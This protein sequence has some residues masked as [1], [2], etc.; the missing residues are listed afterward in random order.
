MP[1][2]NQL[3][4]IDQVSGGNQI[5]TYYSGSGDA[6][7]MS[8]SLLQ[9][10]MQENLSFP[11]VASNASGVNYNPAGAGAVTRTVE[12]KL[13]ESVSVKDFGAVGDGVTDDTAAIQAAID[14]IA[15][16]VIQIPKGVYLVTA[17]ILVKNGIII[18]GEGDASEIR[19]NSD[20]EVFYSSRATLN[21]AVFQVEF[22]S[23][24]I[25]K[26]VTG[27]TTKYDIHLYNPHI[28]NIEQVHIKSGHDD[29]S[30]SSTNVGGIWLDKPSGSTST[31]FMNRIDNCWIQNNSIYLR[32]ITDSTIN[33]GYVWGHTRQFAIR[34]EGGGANAVEFIVGLICSKFNG[35]IW[36]DGA[37]VNQIRIHGNE[38]DGNP[39]LDTGTGVYCPQQ[40]IAVSITGN[41]FWGCDKH[42]IDTTDPVGWTIAGNAFW[43]N[44]AADNF[45]DDVRI[46]GVT[47]QP[48][49]NTV[50][51]N[52]HTI[53]DSRTNKGY[54]IREVNGGAVPTGNVYSSNGILGPT[55][56]V[57]PAILVLSSSTQVGN[58][59]VGSQE[60]IK[61]LGSGVNVGYE[62]HINVGTNAVI[63]ASGTLDLT[64]NTGSYFG[65]P[66]GFSGTLSVSTTRLNSA[67]QSRRTVYAAVGYG[68]TA[69]FTSLASQDGSGGGCSFTLSMAANGVIRFTDTSG[70]QVD[71]RMNFVGTKGLA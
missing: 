64:V 2:I 44:N 38:F 21:T 22:R 33:G 55:G 8:V 12:A 23:L 46:T 37:G 66:G 60:S 54:A 56:Y 71:V 47:F 11:G 16:G 48:N 32:N 62:N 7:K 67:T 45:Y 10:Y 4:S 36:I 50:T 28:C 31:A 34:L 42:G 58:H 14:S 65:N 35:G 17:P 1:T 40:A 26:T 19:V 68:T 63:N 13:R 41:T 15:A 51:G 43:K 25:N 18:C 6:R 27:A 59:G 9:E 52:S 69:T 29:S 5:P 39:L 30:Y 61:L 49:G 20:I 53:D 24:F 3:P 70:Q 57:N